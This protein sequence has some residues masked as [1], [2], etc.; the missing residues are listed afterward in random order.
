MLRLAQRVRAPSR[1]RWSK[2]IQR[3]EFA[4]NS[5]PD[6]EAGSKSRLAPSE[7]ITSW[8]E[9]G[10]LIADVNVFRRAELW[11]MLL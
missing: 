6:P 2:A 7:L 9:D 5:W 11:T 8:F 4:G 10:S 3:R 1:S